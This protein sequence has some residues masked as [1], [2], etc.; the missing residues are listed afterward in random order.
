MNYLRHFLLPQHTNNQRARLLHHDIILGIALFFFVA[1][2]LLSAISVSH[3]NILG[4]TINISVQ[5]LLNDTNQMRLQNGLPPLVYNTQLANAASAKAQNMF[6]YNYWAH[7]NPNTGQTPWVFIQNSGYAYTWAGENLARGYMNAHDAVA[8]W[9]ASPSH[10]ANVL[11]SHYQDVGFSVQEGT[12]TG[13]KNT[14]LIVEEFGGKGTVPF[15]GDSKVTSEIPA[16]AQASE[17]QYGSVTN[18]PVVDRFTFAKSIT[19]F[20]LFLF[21]IIFILDLFLI[22]R[23]RIKRL[24]GHNLDHI[25]FL[26]AILLFIIFMSTGAIQ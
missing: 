2:F 1:T 24:V 11:S 18:S 22:E 3:P 12:L 7:V 15:A 14:V 9:M 17:Q 20:L 6:Q 8:A 16:L 4:A 19:Q 10:R 23:K 25:L 13:E 5:E 21:I 26:L